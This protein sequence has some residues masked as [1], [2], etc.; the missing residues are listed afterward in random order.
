MYF[1]SLNKFNIIIPTIHVYIFMYSAS[2][3]ILSGFWRF[4]NVLAI[5]III[6]YYYKVKAAPCFQQSRHV[7]GDELL[8]GLFQLV[9][10]VHT[11]KLKQLTGIPQIHWN[12]R[13]D[14]REELLK[15]LFNT[16]KHYFCIYHCHRL[17]R[18]TVK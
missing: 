16:I 11:R 1:I 4:I 14:Y 5:I 17:W 15:T 2:E 10:A 8:T 3:W 12:T 9:G 13:D 6:F 7:D 18:T